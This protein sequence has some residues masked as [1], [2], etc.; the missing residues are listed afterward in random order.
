MLTRVERGEEVAVARTAPRAHVVGVTGAPGAGKSTLVGALVGHLARAGR[1]VAVLAIDPSSPRSGG[2]VLGDRIRMEIPADAPTGAV[3]IRSMATR[4]AHGGLTAAV[5]GAIRVLD[6]AGYD[7]IVVE[8]AGVGQIE[9]DVV[10]VSDTTALVLAPGWGDAVQADK[11]GVLEVADVFVVNKADRPGTDD[12]VRDVERM[13]DLGH[14]G[15]DGSWR[16][17]V[18][19]TVATAGDG[20]EALAA[21]LAAH[22]AHLVDTDEL[23]ARRATRARAEVRARAMTVL[24]RRLDAVLDARPGADASTVLT[25]LLRDG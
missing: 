25:A 4:G 23:A 7:V 3:F 10:G 17:P 1:R 13:L 14:A 24:A 5:P 16:P 9:I 19:A 18:V 8:T 12:V 15:I 21:A 20:I 6:A 11:A 22:H 2:A